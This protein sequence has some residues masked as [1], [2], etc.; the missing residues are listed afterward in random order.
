M[1]YNLEVIFSEGVTVGKI[2]YLFLSLSSI[3]LA[4]DSLY[5]YADPV[6][7]NDSKSLTQS[8][9]DLVNQEQVNHQQNQ[10]EIVIAEYKKLY[11][12]KHKETLLDQ[13][14]EQMIALSREIDPKFCLDYVDSD[15]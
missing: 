2:F 1:V 5:N 4:H 7:S 9:D 15:K 11:E 12:N 10:M 14:A 8:R 13:C 6:I 3:S